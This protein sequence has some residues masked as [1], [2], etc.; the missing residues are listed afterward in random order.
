MAAPIK[1]LETRY[2]FTLNV[3]IAPTV[4]VGDI[5]SGRRRLIAIT[6][7]ELVGPNLSGKI[8]SLGADYMMV[9]PTGVVEVHARYAVQMS[10]GAN[11]Y[12]ENSGLRTGPSDE[13]ERLKRGETIDPAE[14]YFRTV[15]RFETA[16]PTYRWLM[17]SIFA[18]RAGRRPGGVFIEVHQVL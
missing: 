17:E 5:G 10:D 16:S 2:A 12:V 11:V 4:E 14:I 15:P 18:A 9:R 8:H 7:G 6:G 3:D 1:P 13:A